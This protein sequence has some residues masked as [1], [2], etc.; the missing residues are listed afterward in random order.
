MR[1]VYDF[2]LALVSSYAFIEFFAR[3]VPNTQNLNFSSDVIINFAASY[4]SY[5]EWKGRSYFFRIICF[6]CSPA[7]NGPIWTNVM[8]AQFEQI[9][10]L[11]ISYWQW[12]INF[13]KHFKHLIFGNL[14]YNWFDT[15]ESNREYQF[16]IPAEK[17]WN[18]N[19]RRVSI[20]KGRIIEWRFG[21]L[22]SICYI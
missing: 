18:V 7:D 10:L 4:K 14:L 5:F 3:V 21:S 22:C 2:I 16:E 6:S 20:L 19:A 8:L 1:C 11:P 15:I 12:C 17:Q 13:S 9:H